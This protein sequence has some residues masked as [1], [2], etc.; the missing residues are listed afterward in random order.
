MRQGGT[1]K[2][3]GGFVLHLINAEA[4]NVNRFFPAALM[5]WALCFSGAHCGA[6][7]VHGPQTPAPNAAHET[8]A[9][10]V[11]LTP[12]HPRDSFPVETSMLANDAEILEVAITK[13]TNPS[14]TAVGIFV[15][16]SNAAQGKSEAEKIL[17][18]NFDLYP[19]DQPGTFVLNPAP[20]VEKLCGE[21]PSKDVEV[22]LVFELKRLDETAAWTPAEVTIAQPRWRPR[23]K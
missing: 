13:V 15:Y 2:Q 7:K 3:P 10:T 22:R 1:S 4:W 17:I 6:A 21:K 19:A 9:A 11:T 20:A 14:R 23:E 12:E 8:A 18:G 16:L 5:T